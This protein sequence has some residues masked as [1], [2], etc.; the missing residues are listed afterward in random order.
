MDSG[1]SGMFTTENQQLA[2]IYWYIIA[3]VVACAGLLKVVQ[4]LDHANRSVQSRVLV[5]AAN[6][7]RYCARENVTR[8]GPEQRKLTAVLSLQEAYRPDTF[9]ITSNQTPHLFSPSICD[10]SRNLKGNHISPANPFRSSLVA[11]GQPSASGTVTGSR[12]VHGGD[13]T[14]SDHWVH[15]RR[16]VLL[17]ANSFPGCLGVG[18]TDP[19]HLS[20]RRQD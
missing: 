4:V 9:N 10:V 14:V 6:L 20:S 13:C 17:G 11:M 7:S 1:S 19:I 18:H 16:R 3:A 5:P 2:H 8:I 15:Y 12:C